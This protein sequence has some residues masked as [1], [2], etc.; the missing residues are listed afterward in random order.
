[1]ADSKQT[2]LCTYLS[3]VLLVGPGLNSVFGWHRPR[4][5]E[6]GLG[7]EGVGVAASVDLDP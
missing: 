6:V 1:M 2:L 3:G 7:F 4:V 5:L